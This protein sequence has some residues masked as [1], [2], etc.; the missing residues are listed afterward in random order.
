MQVIM[1]MLTINK[2]KISGRNQGYLPG[3]SLLLVL[4]LLLHS[5]AWGQREIK[6]AVPAPRGIVVFAGM[7][8][9]DG[10]RLGSYSIERSND[11]RN[12]ENV[13]QM[14]SPAGWDEFY[15]A[16]RL[17]ESDFGFQGLPGN[18]VLRTGWE[19]CAR[20]GVID[21][22]GYWASATA[23]R[24]AAGLAFYD[25]DVTKDK[26]ARYRV[27]SL[28]NGKI[29]SESLSLPVQYPFIP[30]YDA[31]TLSEKN[32]DQNIC[33][34]KWQSKGAN[35]APYFEVRYYEGK[36]LHQAKGTTA[37]YRIEDVTYFIFQDSLQSFR[38]D[39]QYF[40]NPLD[41]W[42][43]RGEATD[44]VLVSGKSPGTTF[45]RNVSAKTDNTGYGIVVTWQSRGADDLRGVR[46]YRSDSYDGKPYDLVATLPPSDSSYTD[47]EVKPDQTTYY[48]LES[49][50]DVG[51]PPRRSGIVFC[52]AL[53]RLQPVFPS[54]SRGEEVPG[55]VAIKVTSGEPNL[56]GVRI[57]RGDGITSSLY[58]ITGILKLTD[59]EVVYVD[60]SSYLSGDQS[61]LDAA[62]T[63]NTSSVESIFSDT[64]IIHP[65]IRTF[66]PS[67][68]QLTATDEDGGVSLVWEDVKVRNRATRGYHVYRRE[69]P[70]GQFTSLLPGESAVDIPFYT[71]KTVLPGK[72]Y[73]YA[74]QTVDDLGGVSESMA[75]ITLTVGELYLP[76]PPGVWL[77]Q[78]AG[79]VIVQWAESTGDIGLKTNLY[80]YRRGEKPS[81][82]K[83]FSHGERRYEDGIVK[84]GELW[85]YFTTFTNGEGRE[86]ARSPEA[87]IRV[88]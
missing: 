8:L 73:E 81:L 17:W 42:G 2:M 23:I 15:A 45:F 32:V 4:C 69:L 87:G 59:N 63:V 43:N 55:G 36:E 85:F 20:S 64:L 88:E 25:K 84:K 39:R 6:L 5:A 12:W 21:S 13:T 40:L 47:R 35:P 29:V 26:Q 68:N 38:S 80:R 16:I 58:P 79:K 53:D 18:D 10:K 41:K 37:T 27:R 57:Y 54:V 11:G 60:T 56:A 86:G 72:S 33:Y 52:S 3:I 65:S 82:L 22:M 61:Y 83:R 1:D 77:G 74:V 71:D 70:G 76:V 67:P 31:V 19:K 28:K 14:H 7:E 48:Y 62:T 50:S 75:V 9:A 78:A 24:L 34:L 44:I 66:P 49:V 51:D 30:E 46:I